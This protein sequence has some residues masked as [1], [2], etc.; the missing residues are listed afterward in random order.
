MSS[1]T[2]TRRWPQPRLSLSLQV[3][4]D[5]LRHVDGSCVLWHRSLSQ[6]FLAWKAPAVYRVKHSCLHVVL[7]GFGPDLSCACTNAGVSQTV[8]TTQMAEPGTS[9]EATAR[10][11]NGT[12]ECT[13]KGFNKVYQIPSNCS[14]SLPDLLRQECGVSPE[15]VAFAS[16][17]NWTSNF[18]VGTEPLLV[19]SSSSSRTCVH[20]SKLWAEAQ[21]P[22]LIGKVS[23]QVLWHLCQDV[24]G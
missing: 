17:Q 3:W 8:L 2:P 10:P 1:R 12:L 23:G 4:S 11:L 20:T 6:Q 9:P 24:S 7:L 15:S 22:K 13:S 19:K 16:A 5:F 18:R 21:S 14:G